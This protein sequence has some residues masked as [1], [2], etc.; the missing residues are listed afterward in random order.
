MTEHGRLRPP[1]TAS[2]T[3]RAPTVQA[4]PDGH[5]I[6]DLQRRAGNRAVVQMLVARRCA[7]PIVQRAIHPEDLTAEMKGTHFTLVE[8]VTVGGISLAKGEEIE[9]TA[10]VNALETASARQLPPKP[11][12]AQ[13]Q[14]P[15]RL[16]RPVGSGVA[17]IAPWSA[18]IGGVVKDFDAGQKR[19]D[20]ENARKGGPRPD[21]VRRLADLQKN[22]V[23]RLNEK[24]IQGSFLNRFDASIKKWVDFYNTKFGYTGKD[25]LDPNLVKAMLYKETEMGTSGEHLEDPAETGPKVKTRQNILQNVDSSGEALLQMIPEEDAALAAKHKFADIRKDLAKIK[26]TEGFLWADPRFVAGVTEFFARPAGG[27]ARNEDYDFWIKSGVR[28]LFHKRS[29]K[30]IKSWEQAAFAYN[31]DGADA[32]RYR[33]LARE[34]MMKAKKAQAAGTEYVP[35]GL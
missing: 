20:D 21:E 24:L 27:I 12:A 4:R 15:K 8:A 9:I 3:L 32:R 5:G 28:W 19:I 34:R 7:A 6:L 2:S 31:G 22:R 17:E 30:K 16:L 18:G 35:D 11:L 26:D 25:P 1:S 23:R 29:G 33:R 10:W 13:F 14:V